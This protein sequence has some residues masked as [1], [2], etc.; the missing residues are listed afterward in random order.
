VTARFD[1]DDQPT[2]SF[3]P[4]PASRPSWAA[5]PDW[6]RRTP[7][8]WFE[9]LPPQPPPAG[10]AGRS[11]LLVLLVAFIGAVAGS[12]TTY[13]AL[14]T[15]GRL[16]DTAAPVS[17]ATPSPPAAATTPRPV[18]T[19]APAGDAATI[20]QVARQVSPAVV[21]I[22]VAQEPAPDD[23]FSLPATGVGSG[24]IFDSAGWILTNRHVVQ[25]ATTVTVQ[26]H[27]GRRNIPGTVYGE[28]TLTDLAIVKIDE[29][30][31][32]AAKIGDSATLQ[33][34]QLAVA[35]GSPL[36]TLTNSVTAG[37]ISA[38]GRQVPVTD[39]VTGQ[40]KVLRNLIQT[41]AAINQGNSGGALVDATG[42]VMGINTAVAGGAQ[43]IGFAIPIN[44]A[45]PLMRQ[46]LAGEPLARPW[47]GIVYQALDRNLMEELNLD[48][49]YGA[50]ISP[51]T[52]SGPSV[53]PD[54]PADAA[55][56][57][58]GDIITHIN[59]R[60]VDSGQGLDD[61]LSQYQPGDQLTLNVLRN[62]RPVELEVTLGTRP[63]GLD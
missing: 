30:D 13:L 60:R 47:I 25:D 63:A 16:T 21:T 43:G 44:I 29:A 18:V 53:I 12:A 45:K 40:Q 5:D 9:P 35:I 37:V 55:G 3:S 24:F 8:R 57:Q 50:L 20:V 32:V 4:P 10:R 17:E 31:L 62:G 51:T 22:T 54:S 2:T 7:E 14:E 38:L 1:P 59:G 11:L 49:D 19:P 33:P 52:P 58:A 28:D 61:I 39:A 15:G 6:P 34:G 42:A 48:I 36:G 41:D 23:P 26:L 56:L 46:A 27:D